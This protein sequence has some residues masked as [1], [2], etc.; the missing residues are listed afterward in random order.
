GNMVSRSLDE[1]GFWT[2]QNDGN[3]LLRRFA[4]SVN[5]PRNDKVRN[6]NSTIE[7]LNNLKSLILIVLTILIFL[8]SLFLIAVSVKAQTDFVDH[9][10]G[11]NYPSLSFGNY[12]VYPTK[13]F[14]EAVKFLAQNTTENDVIMCGPTSGNHIA[15]YAGRFV[16]IGHGQPDSAFLPSQAAQYY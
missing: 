8:P 14:M 7:Q 16:Y 12:V 10:M 5:A 4:Y 6:N 9:K 1:D 2:S 15:A 3:R 13:D 11:A